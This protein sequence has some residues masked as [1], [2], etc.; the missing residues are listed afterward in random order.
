MTR[1]FVCT[2]GAG[3]RRRP[4]APFR[5]VRTVF[6]ETSGNAGDVWEADEQSKARL[7]HCSHDDSAATKFN[8]RSREM[9]LKRFW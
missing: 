7:W 8:G 6:S 9:E 5:V 1:S 3:I 2:G 4:P